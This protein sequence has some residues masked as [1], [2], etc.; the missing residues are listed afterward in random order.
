MYVE[1]TGDVAM[2]MV[3][4][5]SPYCA[6]HACMPLSDYIDGRVRACFFGRIAVMLSRTA[7]VT[8]ANPS[9]VPMPVRHD[10]LHMGSIITHADHASLP[11]HR[12]ARSAQHSEREA[13]A[14]PHTM[15]RTAHKI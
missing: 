5:V 2:D 15:M 4:V 10:H 9:K 14:S 3:V 7:G 1:S 8:Y 6:P 13:C 11:I 12:K